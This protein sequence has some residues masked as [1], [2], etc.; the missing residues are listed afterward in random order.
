MLKIICCGRSDQK[1]SS[2]SYEFINKDSMLCQLQPISRS[3]DHGAH[4]IALVMIEAPRL[5]II[6][7]VTL[8]FQ[9][10]VRSTKGEIYCPKPLQSKI[11]W[12]SGYHFQACWPNRSHSFSNNWIPRPLCTSSTNTSWILFFLQPLITPLIIKLCANN[13]GWQGIFYGRPFG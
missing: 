8:A 2:N 5:I 6:I 1:K 9:A 12:Q 13:Y 10:D 3:H 4:H 11:D 7:I